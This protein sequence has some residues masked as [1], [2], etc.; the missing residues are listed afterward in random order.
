MA[1]VGHAE[2]AR[3]AHILN[4]L[5]SVSGPRDIPLFPRTSKRHPC[6]SSDQRDQAAGGPTAARFKAAAPTQLARS[7]QHT[8]TAA[9]TRMAAIL[10]ATDIF[11]S[12]VSP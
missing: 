11:T 3:D 1:E 4:S 10:R 7:Q 5:A 6:V 12:P 8:R 9:G 2:M